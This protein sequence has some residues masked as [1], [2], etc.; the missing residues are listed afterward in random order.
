MNPLSE[1]F[2]GCVQPKICFYILKYSV[3]PFRLILYQDVSIFCEIIYSYELGRGVIKMMKTSRLLNLI[4]LLILLTMSCSKST[5]KT[6]MSDTMN[7]PIPT[8]ESV[9]A[10]PFFAESTLYF[11]LPPFDKI[12]DVDYKP[13]FE[14]GMTDQQTEIEAI[15]NYLA[16]LH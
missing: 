9:E 15:A 12:D 16:G 2:P 5:H 7:E 6:M 3:R 11:K 14:R 1:S 4:L 8:A 13:A 10:N